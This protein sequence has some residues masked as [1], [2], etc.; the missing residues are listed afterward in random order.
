MAEQL[1]AAAEMINATS[2]TLQRTAAT[3]GTDVQHF[4]AST[5]PGHNSNDGRSARGV[6]N[7]RRISESIERDLSVR[8]T[9]A[10]SRSGPGSDQAI[11]NTL[12]DICAARP[13]AVVRLL[14]RGLAD[15]GAAGRDVRR[16]TG[17]Q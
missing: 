2:K 17:A 13:G 8:C 7:L 6:E 14:P 1:R 3:S 15:R 16:S 10:A 4:T 12:R 9:G 5:L 11:M